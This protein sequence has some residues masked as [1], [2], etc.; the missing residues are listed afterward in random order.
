MNEMMI[1]ASPPAWMRDALRCPRCHGPLDGEP[2]CHNSACALGTFRVAPNGAPILID[3]ERSAIDDDMDIE[4]KAIGGR[5]G[6]LLRRIIKPFMGLTNGKGSIVAMANAASFL[7]KTPSPRVLM[8]GGGERWDG[9]DEFMAACPTAEFVNSDVYPTSNA[10]LLTDAH[11]LAFADETFDMVIA[12]AVLEHLLDPAVAADEFW[13]V[14]KK[15]GLVMADTPFLQAVHMGAYDFMR[16]TP[17]GQR[18]LFK[19]FEEL[20]VGV[21][22]GPM[23]ALRWAIEHALRSLFRTKYVAIALRPLTMPLNWIEQFS[24][25]N[26]YALDA[27]SGS[28]FIGRKSEHVATPREIIAAYRGQY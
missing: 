14:L 24:P 10:H 4:E 21:S 5:R 19:R 3:F 22:A 15:D 8:I 12:Q 2:A 23:S 17:L 25:K 20:D 18:A 26:R 27:C 13:R 16:F 11:H 1:G 9:L 28:Y 7:A 6:N